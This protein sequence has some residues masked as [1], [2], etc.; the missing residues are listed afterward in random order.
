MVEMKA[1]MKENETVGYS[2]RMKVVW[3]GTRMAEKMVE[4]KAEKMEPWLAEMLGFLS[5][6]ELAD[7]SVCWE[8]ELMGL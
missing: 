5:A 7:N 8:V 6:D 2:G 3:M 4:M 1:V